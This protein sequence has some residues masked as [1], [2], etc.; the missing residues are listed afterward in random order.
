MT[1][2][3]LSVLDMMILLKFTGTKFSILL[4]V[5]FFFRK[6]NG[7]KENSVLF[8]PRC[9]PLLKG[10]HFSDLLRSY[11]M[12]PAFQFASLSQNKR[13]HIYFSQIIEKYGK[14]II[15]T[16]KD[17]ITIFISYATFSVLCI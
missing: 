5:L 4:I 13:H 8:I 2:P 9:V 15:R 11:F 7:P 14:S 6:R 3:M 16:K 1:S 10:D 12:V 17:I